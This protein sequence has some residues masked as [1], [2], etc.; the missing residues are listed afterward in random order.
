MKTFRVFRDKIIVFLSIMG[1]GIVTAFADND[2]GGIATYA[3]A[4]AKYGLALLFTMLLSTVC[5]AIA[6]EMSARTGAVT[7]KGLSDLIRERYGVK[8]TLFAMSILIIANIGTTASEF[9]GIATSFEIFGVSRYIS[10]PLVAFAVWILVLKGSYNKIEKIFLMLCLTFASY[11]ISGI[12]VGPS[13]KEVL[14]ASVKPTFI[15]DAEF[16]LMAIGVIGTTVTPWGQFYVQAAVVDK[17]INASDY[18][19]TRWDVLVGAFFTW[20]VAFFIIVATNATLYTN[21]IGIETAGDAAIA[22]EPVAGKY[23]SLLFAFGL[24]GAS[25]LAAFIL[26][27][28]TAYA[29]CEALGFEHAVSDSYREAPVFFGLYTMLVVVGAGIVLLPGI[30]LYRIMLTSQVINGVLLPPIL[31]FMMLI[32]NDINLMGEYANSK[33]YNIVALIFTMVLIALTVLL[34]VSAFVPDIFNILLK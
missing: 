4:G 12:I 31:I 7:G 15:W 16:L 11:A 9:S 8:W 34:L 5:L 33:L 1:P 26:P 18:Q 27:L 2:A 3:A 6:Q 25:M 24:L 17:G 10:V 13:W 28:S 20:L 14:I 21:G 30:S 29:V 22:L 32:A 23:A 19:Y